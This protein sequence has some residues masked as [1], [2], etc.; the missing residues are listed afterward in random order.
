M[1]AVDSSVYLTPSYFLQNGFPNWQPGTI[2]NRIGFEYANHMYDDNFPDLLWD[3][4]L[5]RGSNTDHWGFVTHSSDP[6]SLAYYQYMSSSGESEGRS[7][8][9]D[10]NAQSQWWTEIN[11]SME[12]IKKKHRNVDTFVIDGEGHCSFGLYYPLQEERFETWA[13]PIVKERMVIGN[14]RPSVAAFFASLAIGG[15]LVVTALRCRRKNIQTESFEMKYNL[16]SILIDETQPS[17]AKRI[18]LGLFMERIDKAVHPLATKCQS[19]PWTAGYLL[20]STLY[21]IS[22]LISQGFTHPLDNL[23]LGPSAVGL[24]T[25]GINNPALIIAWSTFG[26]LHHRFYAVVSFLIFS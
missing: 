11:S 18:R 7:R 5:R 15:I 10:N 22:M 8:R 2:M 13:A 3:H 19:W 23:A 9:M 20:A 17:A 25:F 14:R 4:V 1:H 12:Y 21:F 24:S 6:V 26:W 16:D